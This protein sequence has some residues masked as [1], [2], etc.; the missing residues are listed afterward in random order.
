VLHDAPK[1]NEAT[2]DLTHY[3][4]GKLKVAEDEHP[5]GDY[6]PALHRIEIH[7]GP[8]HGLWASSLHDE[9]VKHVTSRCREAFADRF[10]EVRG[11]PQW[12][13]HFGLGLKEEQVVRVTGAWHDQFVPWYDAISNEARESFYRQL[14]RR[15]TLK[16][17]Q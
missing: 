11:R 5:Y 6:L 1:R 17:V 14:V 4:F 7:L 2:G 12:A 10:A 16:T 8:S 15:I 9:L 3:K 13:I